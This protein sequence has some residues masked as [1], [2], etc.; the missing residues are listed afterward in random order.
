MSDVLV[1]DIGAGTTGGT[2]TLS[3]IDLTATHFAAKNPMSVTIANRTLIVTC[4]GEPSSGHETDD[5]NWFAMSP[6]PRDVVV[7]GETYGR[8]RALE[9]SHGK[10]LPL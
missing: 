4:V 1:V 7:V 5:P 10:R 8:V 2:D 9:N 6:R 3:V